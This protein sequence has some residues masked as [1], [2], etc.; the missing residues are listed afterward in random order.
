MPATSLAAPLVMTR[1]TPSRDLSPPPTAK[2]SRTGQALV[3]A[4]KRLISDGRMDAATIED[5]AREAE[6]AKRSFHN[7]FRDREALLDYVLTDVRADLE[8]AVAAVN[9]GVEDPAIRFTRGMLASLR[10]G[11][12]HGLSARVFLHAAADAANPASPRNQQL[13][14]DLQASMSQGLIKLEHV[15]A[16]VV[17]ILGLSDL[18]VSRLLRLHDERPRAERLMRG[19]CVTMLRGL[20]VDARR[21][22]R[23]VEDG[24]TAVFGP[25]SALP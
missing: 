17:L 4:A 22:S 14:R 23:V 6:V 25:E 3:Q 8:A 15:D 11:L 9:T 21:I 24:M 5:I 10:Y 18:G 13:A 1:A 19:I 7:H 16:G 12:D 2:L 20:G